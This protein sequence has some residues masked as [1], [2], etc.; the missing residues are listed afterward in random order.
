MAYPPANRPVNRTDAT[1]QQTTHAADHNG[2]NQAIN[3]ITAELGA[4]PSGSVATVQ[5]RFDAA[6]TRA[7]AIEAKATMSGC[8]WVMAAQT[9]AAGTNTAM[10]PQ[11]A[12][13]VTM[14]T[15]GYMDTPT[16]AYIRLPAS[17]GVFAVYARL[18]SSSAFGNTVDL[19]ISESVQTLLAYSRSPAG[20][21]TLTATG[22]T[23]LNPGAY[24]TFD[25]MNVGVAFFAQCIV[26]VFR[27]A[28]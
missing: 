15:G 3:D 23:T 27:L 5:A 2:A 1:P 13:E 22:I 6:D 8:K 19:T 25:V 28:Y 21:T 17:G 4:N 20:V 24:V 16:A 18:K 10:A 7:T 9:F 26:S 11:S 14:N 12:G